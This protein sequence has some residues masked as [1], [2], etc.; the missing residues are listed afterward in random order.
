MRMEAVSSTAVTMPRPGTPAT[1]KR[2]TR[3]KTMGCPACPQVMGPQGPAPGA[4]LCFL[5]KEQRPIPARPQPSVRDE[6]GGLYLLRADHSMP[7]RE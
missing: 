4:V 3:S 2:G 7:T 1:A 6:K 5:P